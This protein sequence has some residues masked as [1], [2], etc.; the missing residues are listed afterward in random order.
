MS[1]PCA[2]ISFAK[3]TSITPISLISTENTSVH[4]FPLTFFYLTTRTSRF[5]PTFI[6]TPHIQCHFHFVSHS[7]YSSFLFGF[8]FQFLL[9]LSLNFTAFSAHVA[10]WHI[11]R[12]RR[13]ISILSRSD[14]DLFL[15]LLR[16]YKSSF[17]TLPQTA[18]PHIL[19]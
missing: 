5:D 2:I 18:F 9:G 1:S 4:V 19:L 12:L 11:A 3:L 10:S 17:Y 13:N 14:Q 16:V 7:I 8:L 6:Y 15:V